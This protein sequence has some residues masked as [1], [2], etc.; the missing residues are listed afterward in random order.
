MYKLIPKFK[1]LNEINDSHS[2]MLNDQNKVGFQLC[3]Q[4]YI[5]LFSSVILV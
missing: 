1:Y 4:V 3:Y 5:F 2:V